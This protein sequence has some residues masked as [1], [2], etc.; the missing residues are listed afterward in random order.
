VRLS[1]SLSGL[2][3][4][5]TRLLRGSVGELSWNAYRGVRER[6]KDSGKTDAQGCVTILAYFHGNAPE[7]HW[8]QERDEIWC[9]EKEKK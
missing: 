3:V 1:D 5:P 8:D 2:R 4:P 9:C 6:W 7:Y